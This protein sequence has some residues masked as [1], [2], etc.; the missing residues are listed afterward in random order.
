MGLPLIL[1]QS[2]KKSLKDF[3]RGLKEL[4]TQDHM[5]SKI[6]FHLWAMIGA[7]TASMSFLLRIFNSD[8]I[9]SVASTLGFGIF[10]GAISGLQFVEWRK[11]K[12]KLNNF[13]KMNDIIKK[14]QAVNKHDG[15]FINN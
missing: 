8:S 6:A 12:Q 14:S 13:D 5:N 2:P 4:T 1:R 3:K 10:I 9:S 15:V 11:E 7:S